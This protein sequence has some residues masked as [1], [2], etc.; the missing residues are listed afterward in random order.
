[1]ANTNAPNGFQQYGGLGY[2]PT[3]EQGQYAISATN[4]TPVFSGDPVVMATSATT[5]IG[6]GYITQASVTPQ[7]LAISGFTG[8]TNGVVT[9]TF[10]S[11]TAPPVGSVLVLTG[12]STATQLNGAWTV[13]SATATTANFNYSGAAPTT[14]AAT[15]YVF[16]PILGIFSGCNYISVSQKKRL[17]LPY[18][19]GTTSDA[20]T[21]VTAYVITDPNAQFQVQTANS[22]TAA[23]AIGFANIGQNIGVNWA[24]SGVTTTNGNTA[25]GLSTWF[26]D[27]YTLA[28]N[29][30]Y[31]YVGQSYLPFRINNLANYAPGSTT[32]LAYQ[33]LGSI[34]GNDF[35]NPYN[36]IVVGFNQQ[37]LRQFAGI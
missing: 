1:M 4:S 21:D 12:L 2:T 27:Q 30:P 10:T 37:M 9:A 25:S 20:G 16:T 29:A 6:L 15:G 13:I 14:Q 31:G 17:Y 23:T 32:L 36:R 5:G 11:T 26:A 8:P 24:Q 18:W 35:T 3:Y 33:P 22:N 19:P 34:S 7:T 28:A